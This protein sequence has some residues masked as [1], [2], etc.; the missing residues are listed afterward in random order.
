MSFIISPYKL[1]EGVDFG[2]RTGDGG[3]V[4]GRVSAAA[5]VVVVAALNGK[6][7][8]KVCVVCV[9]G[10]DGCVSTGGEGQRSAR[11][12]GKGARALSAAAHRTCYL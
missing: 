6:S 12:A 3:C 11:T 1:V 10:R 5:A 4:C 8:M 7:I 9:A 2:L